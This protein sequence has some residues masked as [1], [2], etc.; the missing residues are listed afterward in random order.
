MSG[1]LAKDAK[2]HIPYLADQGIPNLV[3][4]H[5]RG[6]SIQVLQKAMPT[7]GVIVFA[8]ENLADMADSNYK[9]FIQ[10]QTD[11]TK[12]GTVSN[13]AKLV[14][15]ITVVGPTDADVLDIMIVGKLKGQLA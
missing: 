13:A 8:D 5:A 3:G 9:V 6:V 10:N 11:Q 4:A 12:P 15:Q 14:S 2:G 7:G 1:K